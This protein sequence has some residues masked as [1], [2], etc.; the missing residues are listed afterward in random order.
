VKKPA[1]YRDL[2]DKDRH[3]HQ[4]WGRRFAEPEPSAGPSLNEALA[5]RE[6]VQRR[7][8]NQRSLQPVDLSGHRVGIN[9]ASGSL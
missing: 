4:A 7:P 2:I 6:R 8:A 9:G 5:R 1:F 3:V